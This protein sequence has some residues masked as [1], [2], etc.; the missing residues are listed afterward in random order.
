MTRINL[1]PVEELSDQHLLAEYRELPRIVHAVISKKVLIKDI[2]DSYRLGT[3]HVKF[4]YN[5]IIFLSERYQLIFAELR[6]R[7]F[8]KDSV[9]SASGLSDEIK[10][11]G[12]C[13][14]KEYHFSLDEIAISRARIVEKIIKKASWYKWTSRDRPDYARF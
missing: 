1:V 13:E 12:Y 14:E 11:S 3:G 4:F 8:L 6:F 5:K 10:E 2:P 9:F 7:G